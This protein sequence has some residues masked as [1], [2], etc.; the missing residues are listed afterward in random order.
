MKQ[1]GVA[2][3]SWLSVSCNGCCSCT[4]PSWLPA[5]FSEANCRHIV[6]RVRMLELYMHT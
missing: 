3:G 5:G 1:H 6:L 4:G 2:E